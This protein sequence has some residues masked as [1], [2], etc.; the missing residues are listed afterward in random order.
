[1][2]DSAVAEF[3]KAAQYADTALVH[4]HLGADY[5]RM[6]RLDKA[7]DALQRALAYDTENVQARYL[8]ALIYSSQKDFD[9]AAAEYESIL[10]SFTAADPA[11]LEIYGYLGQ[12]YYSQKKYQQAIDQF[13][14]VLSLDPDNVDVIFLL[15]S[16]Y[17]E[18]QN[19]DKAMALFKKAILIDPQHDESLNSLAYLYAESGEHL[20]EAEALAERALKIDPENGAYLDTLGWIY[21]REGNYQRALTIFETADRYLKD[22]V[23]YEHIGDVYFQLQD[24]TAARKYWNLSLEL[25]PGQRQILQKLTDLDGS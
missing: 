16:L 24:F 14:V 4:L 2:P 8:L 20:D 6:G 13:E 17:L 15:G 7:V 23:I 25:L 10:T 1:M 11:N 18:L 19:R 12:L 9:K 22:P 21:F 3:E 5:A